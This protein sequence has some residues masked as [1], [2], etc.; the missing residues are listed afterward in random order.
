MMVTGAIVNFPSTGS[1]AH[2]KTI[3]GQSSAEG[4]TQKDL[5]HMA[6]GSSAD[7]ICS[8]MYVIRCRMLTGTA[9]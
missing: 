3:G 8:S 9:E 1:H 4:R 6:I 5:I 2:L 7:R